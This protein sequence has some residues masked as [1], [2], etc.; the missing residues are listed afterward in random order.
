MPKVGSY[1]K[2]GSY[3]Q[4]YGDDKKDIEWLVLEV[5]DGKALIISKYAL[6]CQKYN[7]YDTDDT[8]ENCSLREWLNNDFINAAFSDKEKSMV[9]TVTVSATKNP[10]YK[11][12][13]GNS[14]KDQVFLLSITEANNYFRSSKARQCEPTI[15][16]IAK[17]AFVDSGDS[18]CWW[19]LRS[20]GS[21]RGEAA[22]VFGDGDV[23]S[24]G[25]DVSE[26]P[27]AVR[28]A[29]WID[30]EVYLET[31]KDSVGFTNESQFL[32]NDNSISS[33]QVGSYIKFGSYIQDK[34]GN[35]KDIEWLV[36]EV[37][38]N[39]ALVISKYGI[40]CKQ[41]NTSLTDVI[42]ETCTLRKWLNNDFLNAAFTA[43]EKAKIPTVTVPAGENVEYGTRA[44]RATKDQVFLLSIDEADKY[45][46]SDGARCC[47]STEYA[48]DKG[49]IDWWWL[50]SPGI[51][52]HKAAVVLDDGELS[53]IGCD[54][55]ED[56][57]VRPAMWI[58]LS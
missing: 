5:K 16:A 26:N 49:S 21:A 31:L 50:R 20:P 4:D 32:S 22:G 55:N 7:T 3:C 44:G 58:D 1:I 45:F 9:T 42:W 23:S 56:F 51:L 19:W 47:E 54:V 30:F 43:E 36:L 39:K 6:D 15:Y 27:N 14:T 13:P 17:G 29:L 33:T 18:S 24:Y 12:K 53:G 10:E 40:N 37:K 2:F 46:S 28:P 41:Y 34:N 57:V 38:S 48:E 35:K 25:C 11:T 8:W 52:Q